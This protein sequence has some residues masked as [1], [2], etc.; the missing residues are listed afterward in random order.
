MIY[1]K[2]AIVATAVASHAIM[3]AKGNPFDDMNGDVDPRPTTGNAYHID[4]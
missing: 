2:P 4:E 1:S 3:G